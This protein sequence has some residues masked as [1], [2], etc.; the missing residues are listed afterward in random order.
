MATR[1]VLMSD[2]ISPAAG[3]TMFTL[4][5]V[6]VQFTRLNVG[7][8]LE[9]DF[10]KLLSATKAPKVYQR[11]TI[12]NAPLFLTR[13]LSHCAGLQ[14]RHDFCDTRGWMTAQPGIR[15][16]S[17]QVLRLL[18]VSRGVSNEGAIRPG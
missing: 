1:N 13:C 3:F 7:G 6:M 5:A 8:V 14:S 15:N 17:N 12:R 4:P 16:L 18:P 10:K 2:V 9:I 11:S